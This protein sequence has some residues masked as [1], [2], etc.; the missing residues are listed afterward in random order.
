[1]PQQWKDAFMVSHKN[2]DRAKCG[3]YCSMSMG[4]HTCK[5]L[6]EIIAHRFSEYYELAGLLPEERSGF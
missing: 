4:L 2:K 6:L 5:I 1:M 3:N